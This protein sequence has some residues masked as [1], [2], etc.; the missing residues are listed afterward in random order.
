MEYKCTLCNKDYKTYKT[1]WSHNKNIHAD[2]DIYISNKER[3]YACTN[4]NKKFTRKDTMVYHIKNTCKDKDK[5]VPED[6]ITKLEKQLADLQKMVVE[7]KKISKASCKSKDLNYV[8][9]IEKYDVNNENSVYKFGKTNRPIMDRMKEHC[10][11]S[12]ILLIIAVEDCSI[13][14]NNILKILNKDANIIKEKDIGNEYFY[15][16][17]KQYIINIIL[18][19]IV[20][21]D[22]IV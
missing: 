10:N 13:V 14:E 3:N 18:K 22:I 17:D 7:N 15:C 6:K 12:K 8:Y 9:L 4:C 2:I 11:T 16:D 20:Q 1:F 21:D 19:N 5:K